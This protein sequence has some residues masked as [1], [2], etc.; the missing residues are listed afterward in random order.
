MGKRRLH[1][2]ALLGLSLGLASSKGELKETQVRSGSV[3]IGMRR[4]NDWKKAKRFGCSLINLSAPFA[5]GLK[6]THKTGTKMGTKWRHKFPSHELF[7]VSLLLLLLKLLNLPP[8]E[9]P[10]QW[11][12]KLGSHWAASFPLIHLYQLDCAALDDAM[13]AGLLVTA[14]GKVSMEKVV[15]SW[16]KLQNNAKYCKMLQRVASDES[17]S[18]LKLA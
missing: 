2:L 7:V 4:P 10:I 17:T 12:L 9:R 3:A 14:A 6:W 8:F 16:K 13:N 15:W 1:P 5:L 11:K 18:R